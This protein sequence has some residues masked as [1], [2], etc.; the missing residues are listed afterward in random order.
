MRVL[1]AKGMSA[2]TPRGASQSIASF[3]PDTGKHLLPRPDAGVDAQPDPITI[4]PAQLLRLVGPPD[5]PLILD[6]R[7]GGCHGGSVH[8]AR[9]H[10]ARVAG[11][12]ALS[13][14]L[15]R[16]YRDDLRARGGDAAP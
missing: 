13:L 15:S 16:M 8:A 2:T 4:T 14:G 9:L 5:A 6:A 10:T 1:P 12:L 7:A 11:L 3:A